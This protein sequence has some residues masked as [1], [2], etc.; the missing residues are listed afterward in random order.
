MASNPFL[1][2][3]VMAH[4]AQA[5]LEYLTMQPAHLK[6][7]FWVESDLQDTDERVISY[8]ISMNLSVPYGTTS[9]LSAQPSV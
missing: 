3:V 9:V 6:L 5:V 2:A 4:R 8:I 1:E 7:P